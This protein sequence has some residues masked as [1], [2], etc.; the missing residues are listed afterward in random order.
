VPRARAERAIA[1]LRDIERA[2]DIR[3]LVD[4]LTI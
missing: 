1:A 3:S 2:G 4:L